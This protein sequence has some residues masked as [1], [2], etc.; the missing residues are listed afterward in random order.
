MKNLRLTIS[1]ATVLL[2]LLAGNVGA[3]ELQ[4]DK[5]QKNPPREPVVI[6]DKEKE[7]N[8]QRGN[9]KPNDNKDKEKKDK[10]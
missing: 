8:P 2:A 5:D 4:K 10:P 9:D 6:K 7:K 1:G 3:F